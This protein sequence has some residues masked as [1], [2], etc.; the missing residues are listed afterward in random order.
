MSQREW[1][2]MGKKAGWINASNGKKLEKEAQ[3]QMQTQTINPQ[4]MV[5]ALKMNPQQAN[6]LAQMEDVVK[7]VS[8][9][10]KSVGQVPG[11]VL[12]MALELNPQQ[13]QQVS[14]LPN[15]IQVMSGQPAQTQQSVAQQP[16]AQQP[17]ATS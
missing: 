5:A 6:A 8:N 2:E 13:A 3:V 7:I 12:I 17:Q 16:V 9:G 14:T 15:V 10:T 11:D 1:I 4:E